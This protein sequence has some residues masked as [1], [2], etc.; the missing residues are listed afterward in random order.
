MQKKAVRLASAVGVV[1]RDEMATV[2]GKAWRTRAIKQK[3]ACADLQINQG[4]FSRLVNGRFSTP[5]GHACRLF[6]YAK[7]RLHGSSGVGNAELTTLHQKLNDQLMSAWD[8]TAEG[9]EAIGR[10][11]EGAALLGQRTEELSARRAMKR[12]QKG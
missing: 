10:I 4:Q 7:D 12:N 2:I 9:A 8:R 5:K 6:A 1:S 3:E 11:L